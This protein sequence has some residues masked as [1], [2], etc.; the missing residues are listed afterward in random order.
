[1]VLELALVMDSSLRAEVLLE[2]AMLV[3][4]S[5]LEELYSSS[6]YYYCIHFLLLLLEELLLHFNRIYY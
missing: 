4:V 3:T 5:W 6:A 1:M 2:F